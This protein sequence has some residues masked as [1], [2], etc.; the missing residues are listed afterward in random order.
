MCV[1]VKGAVVGCCCC[2][3]VKLYGK[4]PIDT[5]NGR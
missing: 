4:T 2:G 5:A 3:S 1:C